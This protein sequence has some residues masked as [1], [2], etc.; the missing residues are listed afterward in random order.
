MS[1]LM[2][3]SSAVRGQNP[4]VDFLELQ[5]QFEAPAGKVKSIYLKICYDFMISDLRN[6][7]T[8]RQRAT[9]Y[10]AHEFELVYLKIE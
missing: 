9:T 5:G 8:N 6:L 4:E 1:Y 10:S 3:Y 7:P 2:M